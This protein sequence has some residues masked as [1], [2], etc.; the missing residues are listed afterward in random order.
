MASTKTVQQRRAVIIDDVQKFEVDIGVTDKGDLPSS[1]IFTFEI[2]DASD[3]KEDLFARVATIAD[4]EDIGED[5]VVAVAS[6]LTLF[7]TA[8]AKFYYDNLETAVNAQSTLKSFIDQL[9]TDWESYQTQFVTV[10]EITTHPQLSDSI[11]QAA[12]AAYDATVVELTAATTALATAKTAYDNSVSNA[13][14]EN[15]VLS[16]AQARY[17]ESLDIKAWF[18]ELYNAVSPASGLHAQGVAFAG[19]AQ[20]SQFITLALTF[21]SDSQAFL[22]YC[23]TTPPSVEQKAAFQAQITTFNGDAGTAGGQRNTFQNQLATAKIALDNALTHQGQIDSW[24]TQKYNDYQTALLAKNS[25][26]VDISNARSQYEDAQT[27]Y[28]V[29]QQHVDEALA[30]VRALDPTWVPST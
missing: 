26:D 7:R 16:E 4:F 17:A 6:D 3:P 9:V 11:F 19:S 20:M 23:S 18:D 5:R 28:E 2:K 30:A 22:G 15:V 25:A 1:A 14:D 21:R 27:A 24:V 29:A 10:S 13:T 12:V 8:S